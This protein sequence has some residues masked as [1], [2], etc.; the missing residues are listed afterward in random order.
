MNEEQ[1]AQYLMISRMLNAGLA[2]GVPSEEMVKGQLKA[3][4]VLAPALDQQHLD[5]IFDDISKVLSIQMNIGTVVQA[6]DHKPW[7]ASRRSDIDWRLWN[8]YSS[9]QI[10]SGRP[11]LIVDTLD[12]SLDVILDHMGDP[13]DEGSWGRRGL[14]I[15]DVQSGKTGTYIGLMD[16]AADAGYRVFILLTGNT[17]SLRQQTQSRVDQGVIGRDSMSV[18]RNATQQG[19]KPKAVGIGKLLESTS[20]AV[21]MTTM[22][23]D[24]RKNSVQ[25]IDINPGPEN[26][27]VF[28]TKK[29]K[30]VLDRIADWLEKQDNV[31]GFLPGP[32]LLID[33]EADYAS[34]N[35]RN[36]DEDPTAINQGIRRLLGLFSRSS[37]VGFTATPFA[38]IFIDDED[39]HDLF[40]KDFIYGLEAPSN[41]VGPQSLFGAGR[42]MEDEVEPWRVLTDAASIFP[43]SHKSQLKVISLPESL[44][45]AIRTFLLVNAIRDLRDQDASPRAMLVN[46][47]RYN[48]VQ[49]QVFDL[50]SVELAAYRNAIQLHATAFVDG[51]PNE[52]IGELKRTFER[53][54]PDT[55]FTWDLVLESLPSAVAGITTRLANSKTDKKLEQDE[56]SAEEAPRLIAIGGDLLSRGLTLEG[57]TVSYFYRHTVAADTL[58]QMGRWFGYREGYG[59][60]CRLWIDADVAAAYAHAAD[61]LDELRLELKR[62]QVQKLTPEQYGLAVTNHPGALL[63]TARNKMRAAKEGKKQ[64]SLRGRA[65]ESFK[66]SS[67]P[68]IIKSNY[69]AAVTLAGHLAEHGEPDRSKP[70]R[71]IWRDVGKGKIA[72]FLESF[73]AHH[74]FELFQEGALSK[75]VRSAVADDL[76]LWDVVLVS[77]RGPQHQLGSLRINLPEREVG[78]GAGS[79]W[80]VSGSRQRIAGPRDVAA[81]LSQ[82]DIDQA[83]E[84]FYAVEANNEKKSVSDTAFVK[85][86]TK[87]VLLLYVMA[88]FTAT[89]ASVSAEKVKTWLPGLPFAAVMIAIPPSRNDDGEIDTRDDVTYILNKP[90]QRLWFPELTDISLEDEN[91]V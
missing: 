53:E 13:A 27:V 37:Y 36:P 16:K 76:Q 4:A 74:S 30:M 39:A 84:S 24:F 8:A 41:Y 58:M 40:P 85:A 86:L 88:P 2:V 70:G 28:V 21:N 43:L 52:L 29:N 11:P 34:V 5:S 78:E 22:T 7:L 68:T 80:L 26:L 90:A 18:S 59:D 33:D 89:R 46:V 51:T 48:H 55:E 72:E 20:S 63:I 73:R 81:T 49:G 75:F 60:L 56:L 9:W 87:P 6:T 61:S 79:S 17:E 1:S 71:Q 64:I 19:N 83:T 67:D 10:N 82:A 14:V 23:T 62:M 38:N 15:G 54:Y 12:R 35:T 31:G 32:L 66:L 42:A 25:A 3:L 57:L 65:I 77:G 50:V 45:E 47:S 91:D 69:Q 44:R